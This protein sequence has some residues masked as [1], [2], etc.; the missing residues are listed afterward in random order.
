MTEPWFAKSIIATA[1]IVPTFVAI[2]FFRKNFG[3]DPLAFVV[4]YFG[5]TAVAIALYLLTTRGPA[6]VV[7][8]ATA[9][10][11]ILAIGLTIGA[12]ANGL[13]FQAVT[14]A[15]NPGLPPV[16]YATSSVFVFLLSA[17]LASALP[18]LFNPVSTDLGRLAGLALVLAGLYLLA[19][20]RVGGTAV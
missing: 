1:V 2:P 13:L 8:Q 7:P 19:G 4:W 3:V 12:A 11:G 17:L 6:A 15:P 10:V 9:V 18:A 5:G 16:I 20:G 14:L